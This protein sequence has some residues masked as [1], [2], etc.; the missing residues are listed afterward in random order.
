MYKK[1][2]NCGLEIVSIYLQVKLS[3]F[4]HH[5]NLDGSIEHTK[6]LRG[7]LCGASVCLGS[8]PL[9]QL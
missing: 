2:G 6:C 8:M 9:C 7:I 5:T 4:H 1:L 3:H